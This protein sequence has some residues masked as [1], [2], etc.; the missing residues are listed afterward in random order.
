V[1]SPNGS[2]SRLAPSPEQHGATKTPTWE[3]AGDGLA[4]GFWVG[5][6]DPVL[7]G[8]I[9]CPPQRPGELGASPELESRAGRNPV[10]GLAFLARELVDPL[11][12]DHLELLLA[13]LVDLTAI[14]SLG[15]VVALGIFLVTSLAA[16]RLQHETR[17][18]PVVIGVGIA[19]T[20]LVLVIFGIQT[21]RESPETFAA[22]IGIMALAVALDL[23]WSWL[24]VRRAQ[25][26]TGS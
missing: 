23:L 14:A 20:A 16:L 25:A 19:A 10:G 21:L 15:S 13:N 12:A 18:S 4:G 3:G 2:T 1:V 7:A 24:R 5:G 22:M 6:G 26:A 11:I 8:S 17:S 9:A